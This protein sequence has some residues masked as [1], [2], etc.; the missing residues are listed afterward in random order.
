MKVVID[1][2]VFISAALNRGTCRDVIEKVIERHTIYFFQKIIEEY[3]EVAYRPQFQKVKT[4]DVIWQYLKQA[5]ILIEPVQQSFNLID[6]D[7]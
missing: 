2:N 3:L 7:D 6:L 1:C 4:F 5:A